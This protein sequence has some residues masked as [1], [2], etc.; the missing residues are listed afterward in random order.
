MPPSAS[1]E[2]RTIDLAKEMGVKIFGM[3]VD[4]VEEKGSHPKGPARYDYRRD[5]IDLFVGYIDQFCEEHDDRKALITYAICHEAGHASETRSLERGLLFPYGLNVSR[6]LPALLKSEFGI[7]LFQQDLDMA[8]NQVLNGV[9]DYCV[10]RKLDANGM[11][12]VAAKAVIPQVKSELD[13]RKS[14]SYG[15]GLDKF[16][17]L[18]N[19]PLRIISYHFGQLDGTERAILDEYYQ[20]DELPDKWRTGRKLLESCEFG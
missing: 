20:H 17:A 13:K 5:R 1:S 7:S 12:D 15:A 2:S 9:L 6:R 16:N 18:T 8:M 11:K 4:V 10:D 14:G 3:C 19:L